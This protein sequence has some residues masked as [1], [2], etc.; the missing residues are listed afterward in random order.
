MC[1]GDDEM[2]RRRADS[3][4]LGTMYNTT[5]RGAR[6]LEYRQESSLVDPK[7]LVGPSPQPVGNSDL[8]RRLLGRGSCADYGT[9]RSL[10]TLNGSTL[11]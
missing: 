8:Y 3:E 7:V 1:V 6:S 11:V 4:L 2:M 10:M 5:R 9:V